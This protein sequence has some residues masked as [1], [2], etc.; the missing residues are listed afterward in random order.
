[1][2]KNAIPNLQKLII[3]LLI[4]LFSQIS[5]AQIVVQPLDDSNQQ[6]EWK[7]KPQSDVASDSVNILQPGYNTGS[8]VRAVVPG[9]VFSSYVSAGLEKDPNFGDNIYKVDKT[10][11]DRSFWYR[12]EFVVSE[13]FT[14]E[15]IWLNFKGVNRKAEVYLNGINIGLLNGFMDKGKFDITKI[16]RKQGKNVLALLVSI[17]EAPLANYGSPTYISSASWDWMPYVPGLNSG[18]TDK[19]FLSNTGAMVIENPWIR[20]LLPSNARVDL[21][22]SVGVRNASSTYQQAEL[23]GAIQPGNII[24]TKKV[25]VEPNRATEVKFDKRQF[26]QLV[27]DNPKLW[28]PNGYG[29]QNLYTC[30]FQVKLGDKVSDSKKITFGVKQC[31]YDSIGGVL[32]VSINGTRVFIK[33]GNWGM[34]EYLLRCHGKEYDTKVR[35]HKEMNF[36]MIRNWLGSTTDE[37]FYDACDKYGMMVWDD[38]W[39]N[40]NPNLPSDVHCFNANAIEKIQRFR[41]HP[42]IAVWCGNNEGWPEPPLNHWLH[43]NIAT[44]DA[45]DR[46]Y[47]ENSHEGNLSGSG[48]WGNHDPRWYF[49]AYPT[50]MGGTP[51]WGL[52]TETGTAVFPNFE[53]LKKFMP[54]DKLWPRNEMW[55]QHFFGQ[56]AFN[57]TPD[58]YDA[59]I[60]ERYGKPAGIE[61][62]CRKAQLLNIETNKAM[63][64]GWT[65]HMWEDASGIMTWMSQSAYPS[66]VW[67][68]Y[69]YYYDLTGAFWGARKA[70]EPIHIQW[71][72]VNNAI[73]VINTTSRNVDD[74]VAE[75]SVYNT[76]GKEV[77]SLH[78]SK[79][80]SSHSN[81]ATR[82]FTIGFNKDLRNLALNKPAFASSTEA[83]HPAAVTDENGGSRWA[84]KSSNNEWI[85]IDLGKE[86]T[87]NGVGLNWEEA[88]AK[89]YKIQVST[90]AKSWEDVYSNTEGL[91][92]LKHIDFD[93]VT[94]RYVRM[95]GQE[96][97]SWWGYSLWNF[98]VYGGSNQNLELTPV[99]LIKLKL[100]D[101]TGQV[102]SENLYWRGTKRKDFTALN[103]LAKVNLK[104]TTE[105]IKRDGKCFV[106]AKITNP[107]NSP[108]VAFAV[109]VQALNSKTGERILPA[110]MSDNYFTLLKG[111]TKEIQIEFDEQLLKKGETPLLSVEPY[112]NFK[113]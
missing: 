47:Q 43:E 84:S 104:T 44:Y 23:T 82:A 30:D 72:P 28:W 86:E 59:S 89:S 107:T 71:N 7:I 33:G 57:A 37:E 66:M 13:S 60:L 77:K 90:D 8:W 14:K 81:T 36:N 109:W 87:V 11:Y 49:T 35:L 112:N 27:I 34:S 48:L 51:G 26:E 52:R 4:T 54:E 65:D 2:M 18:I 21:S 74:L 12:T 40:A 56:L 95:L 108:A 68:T 42:S 50:S 19:V 106:N 94:A 79:A 92:G 45:G 76:D 111:E 83:G 103:S 38:F 10:K 61:D 9:T 20:T 24:F 29:E 100:K 25:G 3:L 1:M 58:V 46:Y 41:N 6:I 88:Y 32:H 31:S 53:S 70:C 73:K 102:V 39:L 80:I 62:Y 69:D 101:K 67:Q 16:V 55:N 78:E 85:Y 64:E 15:K 105:V 5:F 75:V 17:P 110:V 91:E 99:H 97:G 96:R 22:V 63:Y 113:K 98:E 93:D